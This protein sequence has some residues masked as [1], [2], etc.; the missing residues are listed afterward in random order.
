MLPVK[1]QPGKTCAIWFYFGKFNSFRD[2]NNNPSMPSL[3]AC[4]T[5]S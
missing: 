2:I 5:K 4:Q 3:L 1:L